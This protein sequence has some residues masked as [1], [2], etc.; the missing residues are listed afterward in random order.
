MKILFLFIVIT[1]TSF[2]SLAQTSRIIKVWGT[3]EYCHRDLKDSCRIAITHAENTAAEICSEMN[4]RYP[5]LL[6][7]GDFVKAECGGFER[8]N[9]KC[10][11]KDREYECKIR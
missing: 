1:L 10:D 11:V 5:I 2:A 6:A 7:S 3:S 9:W 4:A 8:G